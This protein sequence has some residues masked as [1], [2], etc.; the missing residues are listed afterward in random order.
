MAS[1]QSTASKAYVTEFQYSPL[2]N[3]HDIRLLKLNGNRGDD[4]AVDDRIEGKLV[5]R[6]LDDVLLDPPLEYFAISYCWGSSEKTDRLWFSKTE[7]LPLTASAAY[8]LR[9][10]AHDIYIWI[11]AIC[12][13][14][15][16]LTGKKLQMGYMWGIYKFAEQ[17]L[18]WPGHRAQKYSKVQQ[19]TTLYHTKALYFAVL[20]CTFGRAGPGGPD[21]DGNMAMELLFDITYPLN[22]KHMTGRDPVE[23]PR[24]GIELPEI[25]GLP[26]LLWWGST[27]PS[28]PP[29]F[30]FDRTRWDTLAKFLDRPYFR[31]AWVLQEL[32]AAKEVINL[33]IS[34]LAHDLSRRE[35]ALNNPRDPP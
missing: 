20:C 2:L 19:S 21:D 17:V 18:A 29:Y 35:R 34:T 3:E 25:E 14:Q 5:H 7:S 31:R 12:I 27:R 16:N 4:K 10:V 1:D 33:V 13:N 23:L 30:H 28:I 8:V 26:T 32:V 15:N 11:D 6:S 9:C 24:P 22:T